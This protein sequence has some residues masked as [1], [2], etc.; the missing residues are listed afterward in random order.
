MS[1]N[2]E[3]D[4]EDMKELGQMKLSKIH[5]LSI[6]G[7]IEG[8]D[9]EYHDGKEATCTEDGYDAYETCSRCD[10][11]TLSVIPALGK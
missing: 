10:Y 7:E 6:I 5:L 8:H 3:T 9:I 2:K 11:T 1:K 4:K